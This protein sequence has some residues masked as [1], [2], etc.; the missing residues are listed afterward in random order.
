M[1]LFRSGLIGRSSVCDGAAEPSQIQTE[2]SGDEAATG[3]RLISSNTIIHLT[4][5]TQNTSLKLKL[6]LLTF[7]IC[8]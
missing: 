8:T 6:F 2:Q 5:V 7:S 3:G 1:F 4:G